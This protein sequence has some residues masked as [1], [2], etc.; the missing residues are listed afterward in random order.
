MSYNKEELLKQNI[1]KFTLHSN[2]G[3]T[4]SFTG[5]RAFNQV[6]IYQSIFDD[7]IRVTAHVA[8]TGSRGVSLE[9]QDDFNLTTGEKLELIVTDNSVGEQELVFEGANELCLERTSH[10]SSTTMVETEHFH[11]CH[12]DVI[13]N[14][15]ESSYVVQCYEGKI[16]DIISKILKEN[17]KT[18]KECY[19]DPT[20]N[21]LPINGKN[22]KPLD[23]CT[24]LATKAVPE[25]SEKLAG[26]LFWQDYQ[27]YKFK[28]ID[29]LF[30]QSPKRK[31]IY[32]QTSYLP[33]SYTNKI[34]DAAFANN[35]SLIDNLRMGSLSQTKIRTFDPYTNEYVTNLYNSED[36]YKQSNNAMDV[37]PKFGTFM[38]L[39]ENSSGIINQIYNTGIRPPGSTLKK[40]LETSKETTF[41]IDEIVRKSMSRF[42]QSLLFRATIKIYGDFTIFPGDII[43]CVFPE[44]SSKDLNISPSKKK[45][46]KYLVTDVA[47]LINAEHCFTKLNIVRDSIAE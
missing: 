6:I 33:Q 21:T 40:Q 46:G 26:Y 41:N 5:S 24:L 2:E 25:L 18:E 11:F 30:G 14:E 38:N 45:S 31:M 37:A 44:V 43:E 1:K 22:E 27:G 42:R 4:L 3:G 34:L 8:D 23:I 32:N 16:S 10:N 20:L 39:A 47:H 29:I 9:E 19:V 13:K 12:P 7:S 15:L 28:S 36:T 17:L 35:L